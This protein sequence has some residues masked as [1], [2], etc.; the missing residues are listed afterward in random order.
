MT[1]PNLTSMNF[2]IEYELP[3][4]SLVLT[5][6]DAADSEEE[7]LRD[8][9]RFRPHGRIVKING[10]PVKDDGFVI[11]RLKEAEPSRS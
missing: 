1:N 9:R 3:K 8:F 11:T 5:F 2:A 4:L 7:A 6:M 10:R